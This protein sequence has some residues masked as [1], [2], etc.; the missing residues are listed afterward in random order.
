MVSVTRA[1]LPLTN[2]DI[3]RSLLQDENTDVVLRK[4]LNGMLGPRDLKL[5]VACEVR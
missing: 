3:L 5:P 1:A 4:C 2:D